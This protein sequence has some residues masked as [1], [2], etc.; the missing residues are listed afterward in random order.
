MLD[1]TSS[2]PWTALVVLRNF[3]IYVKRRTNK[4]V[5][6]SSKKKTSKIENFINELWYMDIAKRRED[7]MLL[8]II[9]LRSFQIMK[10]T[11]I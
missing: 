1:A 8:T 11:E 7:V 2:A 9:P 5:K 4:L 6:Y 10:S 3:C